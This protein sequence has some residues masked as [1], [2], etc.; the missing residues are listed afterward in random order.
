MFSSKLFLGLTDLLLGKILPLV[1]PL[2]GQRVTVQSRTVRPKRYLPIRNAKTKALTKLNAITI[3]EMSGSASPTPL[4][5]KRNSVD[6][7]T[8][9]D[10][11]N[12]KNEDTIIDEDT[13]INEDTVMGKDTVIDEDADTDTS[14]S[15]NR[16]PFDKRG[17]SPNPPR[18]E[19]LSS[20]EYG[21]QVP[22]KEETLYF[23]FQNV[24]LPCKPGKYRVLFDVV[25]NDYRDEQDRKFPHED[26]WPEGAYPGEEEMARSSYRCYQAGVLEFKHEV[27]VRYRSNWTRPIAV[28]LGEYRTYLLPTCLVL[29][30]WLLAFGRGQDLT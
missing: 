30:F 6:P 29:L 17:A 12:H 24:R 27:E 18:I 28:Y 23:V 20:S 25:V 3:M 22:K 19:K 2:Y 1:H 8:D 7:D 16:I 13:V 14:T 9:K 10:T 15:T 4:P 21:I 11:V 5:E 26:L